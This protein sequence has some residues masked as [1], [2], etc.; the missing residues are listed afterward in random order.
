MDFANFKDT[1]GNNL[2]SSI[3]GT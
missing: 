3:T 1:N 2:A